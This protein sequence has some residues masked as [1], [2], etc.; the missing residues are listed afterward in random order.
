MLPFGIVA[1]TA[2]LV[3]WSGYRFSIGPAGLPAPELWSGV[4]QVMEDNRT[5]HLAYFL[6][7]NG[8]EGW[9]SFFPVLLA[10]KTPLAFLVLFAA[11]LWMSFKPE[12][13]ALRT[14]PCSPLLS[15]DSR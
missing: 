12:G 11:G 10:V 8:A 4:R 3:V 7:E 1:V 15:W 14:P 13:R 9:W 6:G 5:G 2:I